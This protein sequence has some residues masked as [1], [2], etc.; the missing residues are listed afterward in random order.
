MEQNE[1]SYVVK[2][3][4]FGTS[5]FIKPVGKRLQDKS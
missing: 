1:A 4:G 3:V 5:V 2:I